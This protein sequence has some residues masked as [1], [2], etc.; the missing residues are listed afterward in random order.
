M[1]AAG[2]SARDLVGRIRRGEIAPIYV[3]YGPERHLRESVLTALRAAI[4]GDG[5]DL[6]VDLLIAKE[7]GA[8]GILAAARTLP[9]LVS[10]RLV[11]VRDI[12]G[13]S[14]ADLDALLPYAR[15]PNEKTC[16]VLAGEKAD[17]RYRFFAEVRRTGVL[18]RFEAPSGRQLPAWIRQEARELGVEI[19]EQAASLLVE[20]LG[21]D[22]GELRAAL[23]RL[24]LF[25]DGGRRPT[26]RCADVEEA[27]MFTRSRSVFELTDAVGRRD[28]S[29]A[30]TVL[31]RMIAD[32][33]NTHGI[34]S[35]LARHI[36]QIWAV[37]E[38]RGAS[39]PAVASE[40]GVPPFVAAKLIDQAARFPEAAL[41]RAHRALADAD[42]QLKWSRLPDGPILER[43]VLE[44]TR[45]EA[46]ATGSR[47]SPR[48]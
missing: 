41:D 12:E 10:R 29:A 37:R 14:A 8:R 4:V 32:R 17:Q 5:S 16:L 26:I 40:V 27:V 22:L 3:L 43:L 23:E 48:G 28:A 46:A 18:A 36:R 30:L 20:A 21:R 39:A 1:P 19:E 35:M 42:R 15:R 6:A 34:L 25:V 31:R 7:A 24:A 33:Q 11:I 45:G 13:L 47:G 38:M 44:M 2:P 9:M